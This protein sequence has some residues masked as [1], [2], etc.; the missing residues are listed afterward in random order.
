M[1][2]VVA[3]VFNIIILFL[4]TACDNSTSQGTIYHVVFKDGT[5]IVFEQSVNAGNS[6]NM[7][8]IELNREGFDF[9]GWII[10]GQTDNAI[11]PFTVN[12][13]LFFNSN[14][15]ISNYSVKFIVDGVLYDSLTLDHGQTINEPTNVPQ[16]HGYIFN[17]W[18]IDGN[19]S[20]VSFPLTIENDI[21]LIA[22]F[23]QKLI[24]LINSISDFNSYFNV[25]F[26]QVYTPPSDSNPTGIIDVIMTITKKSDF[27]LNGSYQMN[28]VY[29]AAYKGYNR[30]YYESFNS[31]S[32][33]TVVFNL[34]DFDESLEYS[35]RQHAWIYTGTAEDGFTKIPIFFD[36]VIR[37]S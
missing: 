19:N 15:K 21:T 23:T 17:G 8:T 28:L 36:H 18:I 37:L 32:K 30:S 24:V 35:I 1:K 27:A 7:P 14:F 16:K 3:I 26:K 11:F 2:K 31:S 22:K 10:D 5:D 6:V 20:I 13:D 34:F 9:T 29:F 25:E 4:V 33:Y 12:S